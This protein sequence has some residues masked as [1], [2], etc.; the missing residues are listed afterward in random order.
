MGKNSSIVKVFTGIFGAATIATFFVSETRAQDTSGIYNSV[1]IAVYIIFLASAF[2]LMRSDSKAGAGGPDKTLPNWTATLITL[3]PMLALL[4]AMINTLFPHLSGFV[5]M[6][7]DDIFTRPGALVRMMFELVACGVFMSLLP[8][9]VRQK[10]WLAVALIATL[11]LVLF[12]MGMEE[13]SWGQRVFQW[14]TT[15]YFSEHNVQGE[16][17]LHN[18]NTQ[19]FQNMLFFGGF[20]LLAV[21]PF[22]YEQLTK[23][24]QKIASLKFLINFMP[25]QWMLVAFG[26]GLMFTDPFNAPYGFHWGSICFQLIATLGLLWATARRARNNSEQYRRALWALWCAVT[27]LTLSL[28]CDK[29]WQLNQGLPTEYIKLFINFGILCWT[30]RVRD[31]VK[32]Q[33]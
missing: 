25:E 6:S 24:L 21:L 18:L 32:A 12:V 1:R 14:Q 31:T 2:L 22:F 27:V 3:L 16:T 28:G 8:R 10:Q 20:I 4:F 15:A 13:I 23:T 33:I 19:L 29:L 17:N 11:S 7:D 30:I 5:R 26:A 9:F